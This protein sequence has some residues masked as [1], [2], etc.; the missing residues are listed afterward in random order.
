MS[1][2]VIGKIRGVRPDREQ[3]DFKS[4]TVIFAKEILW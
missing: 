4:V 1:S 2:A 3:P